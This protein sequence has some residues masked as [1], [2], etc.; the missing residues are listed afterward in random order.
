MTSVDV[1]MLL[2]MMSQL[3]CHVDYCGE[4]V[5]EKYP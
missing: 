2:V 4:K 1:G 5:T 3:V